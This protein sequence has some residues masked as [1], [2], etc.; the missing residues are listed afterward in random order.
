MERYIGIDV[1]RDSTT[2]SVVSAT[3]KRVRRE[4]VE[5]NGQV[6]VRY[7][8][9]LRGTLHVCIEESS[10]SEWLH[11]VLSPHVAKLVVYRRQWTPGAKSD[12]IEPRPR[13]RSRSGRPMPR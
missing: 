4:I 8:M 6:L 3:G 12:A 9:L 10:W 5:T 11:E 7:L 13:S 2:I 1:H